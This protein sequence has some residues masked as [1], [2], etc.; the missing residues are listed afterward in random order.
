MPDDLL[1]K[2]KQVN[3]KSNLWVPLAREDGKVKIL[4]DNPQQLD[5]IDS[6]KSLIPAET[7]AFSLGLKEEILQFLDYFYGALQEQDDGP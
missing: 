5:K 2:L 7:S 6:V 4:L 3:L 1:A